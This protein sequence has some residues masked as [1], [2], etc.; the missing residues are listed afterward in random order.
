MDRSFL[1]P[2]LRRQLADKE[3]A[4]AHRGIG[5]AAKENA[6]E[7]AARAQAMG[8]APAEPPAADRR[9]PAAAAA[10]TAPPATGPCAGCRA[11]LDTEWNFCPKC[12]RDLVADSDPVK[13]LGIEPFV[14]A[15]MEEWL[16]RGYLVRDLPVLGTHTI[17][18]KTSQPT[19]AKVV[20]KYFLKGEYKDEPISQELFQKLY[21]MASAAVS[22]FSFDGKPIGEKLE[23]R[24]IFLEG[25]GSPFADMVTHRV[26]LLNRAWTAF[27]NSKDSNRLLGS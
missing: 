9:E 1:P 17:R 20:D 21:K 10:A 23:E 27:F 5:G 26:A 14:D 16:F 7:A 19:D 22:L 25:K 18:V 15:D 12:G 4:R 3:A 8:A 2:D 13:W 11:P 6:H 24:M